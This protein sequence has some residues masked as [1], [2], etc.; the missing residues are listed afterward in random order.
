VET[1]PA[2]TGHLIQASSGKHSGSG[3]GRNV[4]RLLIAGQVALTLLLM[5]GAGAAMKSFLARTHTNLGFEPSNVL[6]IN[7]GFPKGANPTWQGRLNAHEQVRKTV[8]DIPALTSRRSPT[9]GFLRSEASGQKSRSK[10]N[11]R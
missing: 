11:P 1:F 4:H 5:A 2:A 6:S 9:A 8:A 10:A 7:V 3:H